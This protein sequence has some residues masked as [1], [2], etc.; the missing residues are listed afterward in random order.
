VA[1]LES[2]SSDD[3]SSMGDIFQSLSTSYVTTVKSYTMKVGDAAADW[4]VLLDGEHITEE[5]NPLDLPDKLEFWDP[6]LFDSEE[7]LLDSA[8]MF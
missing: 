5:E 3:D 2:S 1:K 7:N 8:A 4:E 6:D